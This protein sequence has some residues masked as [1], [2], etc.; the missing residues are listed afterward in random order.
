[1]AVSQKSYPLHSRVV[2]ILHTPS[3]CFD[4]FPPN[5]LSFISNF[6]YIFF[7]SYIMSQVGLF[8]GFTSL[9]RGFNLF[10][11]VWFFYCWQNKTKLYLI[12]IK[13]R[14]A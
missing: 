10:I 3:L 7:P 1:M 14:G 13:I 6:P 11:K 2:H 8:G 4:F 9:G 12:A 5:F